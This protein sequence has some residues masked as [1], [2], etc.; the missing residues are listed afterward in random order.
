[1]RAARKTTSETGA[2]RLSQI[3]WLRLWKICTFISVRGSPPHNTWAGVRMAAK[4]DRSLLDVLQFLM[5]KTVTL[6][7]LVFVVYRT[8]HDLP[9]TQQ[10]KDIQPVEDKKAA[11]PAQQIE[12]QGDSVHI[13]PKRDFHWETEGP[14]KYRPFKKG[15]YK[16]VMGIHNILPED[17]FL[18]EN[19]YRKYTDLKWSYA[20]DPL[21]KDHGVFM[22]ED[23]E[24]ATIEFYQRS[25]QFMLDRYPDCFE[26][27]GDRIINKI[28]GDWIPRDPH[29]VEDK[30]EL[31]V[32][33][34][35]FL[36]EDYIILF[37]DPERYNSDEYIFKGGVFLFAAGFDPATVFKTPLTNIHGPVPDYK[38]KLRPQMNRFFEK[39]KPNVWVR[40]NNW[41][42]QTHN[43][44]FTMGDNKGKEDEEIVSIDPGTLDFEREVFFRSERQI[45]TR[46]PESGAIVF[47]IRTYLTPMKNI[48]DEG[49]ADELIGGIE[50]MQGVIGQYKRRPEW[51]EAVVAYLSGK[52]DGV[53]KP[54]I[55]G[56]E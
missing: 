47:S 24:P 20:T 38:T 10:K 1:M 42:I 41:S 11:P 17:W 46:L 23:C 39:L 43:K 33:L 22:A 36:E 9:K 25:T 5:S 53:Q 27:Q 32:Y 51:A 4:V 29:S 50:G 37:P 8:L 26:V 31:H 30:K 54:W 3:L 48:R 44:V 12:P 34:S 55:H 49:L 45:L 21:L 6:P 35:R 52:S 19:S 28:R 14:I 15:E 56:L 16:L 7:L 18:V 40:R 13:K 2:R